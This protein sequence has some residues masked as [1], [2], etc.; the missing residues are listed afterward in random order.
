MYLKIKEYLHSQDFNQHVAMCTSVS[1]ELYRVLVSTLLILFIPQ[2]CGK[3]QMCTITENLVSDDNTYSTGVTVNFITFGFFLVLY[4][5]EIS[6]EKKLIKYLE[7]NP[8]N[9]RDN[10][11]LE[12]IFDFIPVEYKNKIYRIDY[13][14][15]KITY[16]CVCLFIINT[17]LSGRI[18]YKY[19]LGNQT[20]TTFI[21]NVLFM[22]TKLYDTYYVANTNKSIFYSAYIRDHVQFNDIDPKFKKRLSI[23][24]QQA[25]QQERLE[26][27]HEQEQSDDN[28]W[29]NIDFPSQTICK[30]LL[31]EMVNTIADIDD[32]EEQGSGSQT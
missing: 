15:K 22:F 23:I 5:I 9:T 27:E 30:S 1:V 14:Y 3:G 29:I 18:I 2:D 20:T 8:Q 17:I 7:V 4:M 19:S 24:Y 11:S 12:L 10:D 16:V 28:D 32:I 13:Y 21:T 31:S 26:K 25:E 6:R